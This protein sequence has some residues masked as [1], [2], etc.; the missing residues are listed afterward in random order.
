MQSVKPVIDRPVIVEGKYDKIKLASVFDAVII[1][2]DGFGIF[3]NKE[4]RDFI[5]ALAKERGVIVCTDSDGAGKVIRGHLG[6]LVPPDMIANVYIPRIKG[7]EK[8]KTH[9]SAEGYIGVEGVDKETLLRVFAPFISGSETARA[10]I[11]PADLYE[12]GLCG[13]ANSAR[14][15]SALC[16][17]LGLPPLSSKA[18]CEAV[19]YLYTKERIAAELSKITEDAK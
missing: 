8:R 17:R 5:K 15:R 6:G 10:A 4:K 12:M 18:F 13:K 9:P 11:T 3:K 14:L 1:T 16:E 2:T 7:K 19:N